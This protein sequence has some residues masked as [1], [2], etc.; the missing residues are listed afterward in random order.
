MSELENLAGSS[1]P[2]VGILVAFQLIG[3]HDV[4]HAVDRPSDDSAGCLR[5]RI[6]TDQ[7]RAVVSLADKVILRHVEHDRRSSG[8]AGRIPFASRAKHGS[9]RVRRPTAVRPVLID[10]GER[11]PQIG[12][13]I[14]I[15]DRAGG[16]QRS[17]SF[18]PGIGK[19]DSAAQTNLDSVRTGHRTRLRLQ[20]LIL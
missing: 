2:G 17:E 11:N 15:D 9:R 18:G 7:L 13:M 5:L 1:E 6:P 4:A 3:Q 8:H 19:G 16:R 12:L 10:A 14:R 20:R